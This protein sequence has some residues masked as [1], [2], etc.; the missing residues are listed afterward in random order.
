MKKLKLYLETSVISA[1]IDH[2]EPEKTEQTLCLLTE[3]KAKGHEAFIS[4]IVLV[5]IAKADEDTQKKL[6][7]VVKDIDPEEL[8]I[9]KEVEILAKK[10]ISEGV[11]PQKYDNDALHIAVA[12]VNDLDAVVSWNFAHMVKHK[13]R[14]EVMGIN[15]FMG[16]RVIDICTPKEVTKDV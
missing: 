12:S 7:N 4:R 11:I 13:T 16:Y 15:T 5:E 6:L 2:R 9:D 1:A 10:Y 3:I 8:Y 14:M